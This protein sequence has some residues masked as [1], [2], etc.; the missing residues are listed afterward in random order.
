MILILYTISVTVPL[1]PTGLNILMEYYTVADNTVTFEWDPPPGNGPET[2]VDNYTI[3]ITPVSV[4]HP[5]TNVGLSSPWNVTLNYNVV[6]TA[7]I[8]AVNCA[9]ESESLELNNIEYG[10][11]LF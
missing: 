10:K 3:T 2:I 4:S 5:M 8:V 11:E 9:G 6:Y 1:T 7:T